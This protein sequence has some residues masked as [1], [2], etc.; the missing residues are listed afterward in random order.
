[1]SGELVCIVDDDESV[2]ESLGELLDAAGYTVETF[3]SAARFLSGDIQSRCACLITDIR[4]PEMDGLALQ[5]ELV[6]RGR[7]F[8]MIII[9]GHGDVPLAVRAMRAGASDFI[10]KPFHHE[11]LLASVKRALEVVPEN[12]ATT[13]PAVAERLADLTARERE[14]M[15]LM[16][17]GHPN[18]VIAQQLDISFRTVEVHRTRVLAKMQVKNVAELVRLVAAQLPPLRP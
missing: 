6:R 9:T 17:L 14:V 12:I 4:M 18:K 1:M 16:A 8:P 13:D 5:D 2:R 11:A 7:H 10:E 15:D 3:A